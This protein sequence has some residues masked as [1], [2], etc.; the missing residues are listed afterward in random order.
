MTK[1]KRL[2]P[3]ARIAENRERRAAA[4]LAASRQRLEEQAARLRE[5]ISYRDDYSRRFQ[6]AG[7]QGFDAAR[8]ADYRR[9]LAQLAEAIAWQEQRLATLRRDCEQLQRRWAD[10]H[11]R[12]A[13]LD[14]AIDRMRGEERREADRREQGELDETAQRNR[15]NGPGSED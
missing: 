4:E 14:K 13:A 7:R 12:T 15:H 9:I 5:L 11:T 1:S 6:E 8:M 10:T 3:V 2:E